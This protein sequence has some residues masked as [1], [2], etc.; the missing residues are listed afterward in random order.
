MTS[1]EDQLREQIAELE[2]Q[3]SSMV[4]ARD[5][6]IRDLQAELATARAERDEALVQASEAVTRIEAKFAKVAVSTEE[7]LAKCDTLVEQ[8]RQARAWEDTADEW[9][10]VIAAAYPTRSG[11][12][13]EYG[14]AMRM[15]SSRRSKGQIVAL[16]NWLLVEQSNA[17]RELGAERETAQRVLTKATEEHLRVVKETYRLTSELAAVVRFTLRT[18]EYEY[19]FT[20]ET[21]K[22]FMQWIIDENKKYDDRDIT[23]SLLGSRR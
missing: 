13:D 3:L 6:V 12:H 10:T 23:K 9:S 18:L 15:V 5:L 11:S 19:G 21:D 1:V 8:L 7:L 22:E 2:N 16:V 20:F 14:I 17:I 4:S